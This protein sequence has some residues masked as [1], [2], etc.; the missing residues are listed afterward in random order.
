M[1]KSIRQYIS[2][3][4]VSALF[5]SIC[6]VISEAAEEK[7][8]DW[9]VNYYN[10]EGSVVIDTKTAYEGES[11]L[12]IVNVTPRTSNRFIYISIPVDVKAGKEY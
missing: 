6:P 12:K 3:F 11:S 4:L 8:G 9:V 2:A 10:A 7:V 1:T 5:F